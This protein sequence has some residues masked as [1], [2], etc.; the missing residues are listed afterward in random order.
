MDSSLLDPVRIGLGLVDL[1]DG[2]DDG[3]A[4]GLGVVDGFLGLGHDAVVGGDDQDDDVGELGPAGPELGEGLVAR[5][6]DEGDR[7]VR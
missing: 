1:V 4:G 6:V 5:R 2:H 7:P 3:D